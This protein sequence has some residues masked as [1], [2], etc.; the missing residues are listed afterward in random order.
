MKVAMTGHHVD[1]TDPL[2][3]HVQ[4]KLERLER[5]FD[6]IVDIHVTLTV[7]KKGDFPVQLRMGGQ[8]AFGGEVDA[9]TWEV[10][11]DFGDGLAKRLTVEVAPN[12]K[13]KVRCL[14]LLQ[15]CE[16]R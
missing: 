16:T 15:V 12:A 2:R 9:G 11:A 1:I 7:E 13:V 6:H 5:H 14:Q 4:T 8:R 10:W 3:E